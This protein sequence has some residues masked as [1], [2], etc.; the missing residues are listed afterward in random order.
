[1]PFRKDIEG[2]RAIA[3][4]IVVAYQAALPGFSGGFTGVDVFFVLSGYLITGLLVREHETSGRIDLIQFYARRARRLLPAAALVAAATLVVGTAL[5]YAPSEQRHIAHSAVAMF[6]Y[7]SNIRFMR[8]SGDYF[9]P[10]TEADPFLHTWSLAVEE[11]F[12]FVWPVLLLLALRTRYGIT[13]PLMLLTLLSFVSYV[14]LLVRQPQW[15][16][17]LMPARAWEFGLGALAVTLPSRPF[18]TRRSGIVG[19][20]SATGLLLTTVLASAYTIGAHIWPAVCTAL[21]LRAGAHRGDGPLWAAMTARPM[22]WL[23]RMSYGIYLWHWPLV[24]LTAAVYPALPVTYRLGL[25][26]ATLL[27]A[28]ASHRL[29]EHPLRTSRL[30]AVRP[31]LTVCGAM[32]L[33]ACGVVASV[34]AAQQ[35]GLVASEPTLARI[36]AVAQQKPHVDTNGCIATLLDSRPVECTFGD[37]ASA[38]T[39]VLFGDSHASQWF[40]TLDTIAAAESWRLVTLVKSSCPAANVSVMSV[41]LHREF[42]ECA[43]WRA[44]AIARVLALR[45]SVVVIAHFTR[46]YG[47]DLGAVAVGMR[48]VIRQLRAAGIAVALIQDTPSYPFDVPNCVARAVH[49]RRESSGCA[50]DARTAIDDAAR[51]AELT[52]ASGLAAVINLTPSLCRAGVC[53]SADGDVPMYRDRHHLSVNAVLRLAAPLQRALGALLGPSMTS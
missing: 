35:A 49:H 22:Q 47:P 31:R 30:L 8:F 9:A 29:L 6:A 40:P 10:E 37:T 46:S 7:V 51:E 12:Y 39:V 43:S 4:G 32:A 24:V 50:L 2:L 28:A 11:Q 44:A 21:L 1:M 27:L 25:I 14:A 34:I 53:E 18:D 48:D 16:F 5:V 33:S 3:A 52:A 19:V 23:G 26:G 38:T 45:P 42:H 41:R 36:A 15:A 17:F 20:L 13:R